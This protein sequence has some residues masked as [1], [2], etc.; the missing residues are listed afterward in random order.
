M[1]LLLIIQGRV[2]LLQTGVKL[3]MKK[4]DLVVFLQ[5]LLQQPPKW[6]LLLW[7]LPPWQPI[8]LETS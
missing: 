3:K 1:L 2:V 6:F 5:L 8:K 7:C 4:A